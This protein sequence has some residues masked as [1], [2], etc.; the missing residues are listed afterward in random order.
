[1]ELF[2]LSAIIFPHFALTLISLW[3][4]WWLAKTF[5]FNFAIPTHPQA[6]IISLTNSMEKW[7]IKKS[8][9]CA[10]DGRRMKFNGILTLLFLGSLV[11]RSEYECQCLGC[12]ARAHILKKTHSP[13][14]GVSFREWKSRTENSMVRISHEF[15]VL[16]GELK[17]QLNSHQAKPPTHFCAGRCEKTFFFIYFVWEF[18][19]Q[20]LILVFEA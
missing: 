10:H 7:H 8:C 17:Q 19:L 9:K 15:L 1:M 18:H 13:T 5:Q 20:F 3:C 14:H 4:L 2:F 6:N 11:W 16:F 12:P